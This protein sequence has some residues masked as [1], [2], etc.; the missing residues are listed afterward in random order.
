MTSLN[1]SLRLALINKT[2]SKKNIAD[3]GFT[4]IELMVVVGIVGVLSAV[5]LPQFLGAKEKA[6]LGAQINE[7][8]ALAKECATM[9]K[10]EG[11][12]PTITAGNTGIT[13]VKCSGATN[14]DVPT[15]TPTYTTTKASTNT[16]NNRCGDLT[17]AASK[18][19]K[20]EV[21]ISTGVLT[22]SA[23]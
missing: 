21:D 4:L 5:A 22:Y 18:N 6:D 13:I 8:T 11:P 1:T 7:A 20:V 19:C 17:L 2:K 16:I 15:A 3:K 14:A 12:Y 10:V 23:V 9:L